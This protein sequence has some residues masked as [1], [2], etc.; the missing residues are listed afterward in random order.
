MFLSYLKANGEFVA[1]M[2]TT[3]YELTLADVWGEEKA[4]IYAPIYGYINVP[5]DLELFYNIHSYY[6]DIETN[7]IKKK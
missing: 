2:M 5:D 6:Y 3:E 4:S 7:E 1:P